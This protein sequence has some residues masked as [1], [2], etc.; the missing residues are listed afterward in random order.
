MEGR[1]FINTWHVIAGQKQLCVKVSFLLLTKTLKS[2]FTS[3]VVADSQYITGVLLD[4]L[5]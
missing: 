3:W 5:L 1:T 4:D 2:K